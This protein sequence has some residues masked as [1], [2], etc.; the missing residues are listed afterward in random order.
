MHQSPNEELAFAA[1]TDLLELIATRQI[2]PVELTEL[3][4]NR[5]VRLDTQLHAFLL[6]N[7]DEAMEMARAAEQAVVRGD[8]LGPLHGLPWPS[9]YCGRKG[10]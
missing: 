7:H 3:Y 8:E 2:S 4:F 5:I 10:R 6:L 1:A 9:P